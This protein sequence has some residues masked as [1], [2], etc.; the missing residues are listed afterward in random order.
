[1]VSLMTDRELGFQA[2]QM[3]LMLKIQLLSSTLIIMH[4][5]YILWGKIRFFHE[6]T[7][8]RLAVPESSLASKEV[9]ALPDVVCELN[10]IN[11]LFS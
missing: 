7:K 6:E 3:K 8:R 1:M 4:L 10:L 5:L 9:Q 2:F 11:V